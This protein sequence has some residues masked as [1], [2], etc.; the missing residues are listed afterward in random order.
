MQTYITQLIADLKTAQSKAEHTINKQLIEDNFEAHIADV[1]R[2][3]SNEGAQPIYEIIGFLPKYFPPANR[4][5]ENQLTTVSSAL[6]ECL[7]SWNIC[8]DL[9]EKLPSALAYT[10]LVKSLQN[11]IVL[12]NSEAIHLELCH[13]DSEDCP[14]GTEY[15]RC[16]DPEDDHT[17]ATHI[18]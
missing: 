17:Q 15:C 6:L 3:L 7:S 12:Q 4:L 10:L 8:I 11:K 16:M 14:F 5:N 13:Y 2:Y 18:M 9:P 1:E